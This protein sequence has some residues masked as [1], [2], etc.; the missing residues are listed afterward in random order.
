MSLNALTGIDGIWTL[1]ARELRDPDSKVLMPLRA[2]MGFGPNAMNG[3]AITTNLSL[4][5]LTGIDGI[6]T[7]SDR[8]ERVKFLPVLMP[9]RA[10]MGFGLISSTADNRSTV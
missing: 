5:A 1:W 10:L 6:W 9:L 4:N 8:S 3:L 2:L 7:R